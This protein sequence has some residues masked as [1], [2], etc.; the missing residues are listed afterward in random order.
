M[1]ASEESL[2]LVPVET[3]APRDTGVSARLPAG[4]RQICDLFVASSIKRFYRSLSKTRFLTGKKYIN[5]LFYEKM[6]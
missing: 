6:A 3:P 5:I 1:E 2:S 4:K